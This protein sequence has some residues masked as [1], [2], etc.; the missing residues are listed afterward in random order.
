MIKKLFRS[1]K[2][3]PEQNTNLLAGA[4]FWYNFSGMWCQ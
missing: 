1:K 2:P 4:F 3:A